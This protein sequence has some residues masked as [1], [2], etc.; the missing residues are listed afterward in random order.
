MFVI[1]HSYVALLDDNALENKIYNV[2]PKEKVLQNLDR[3]NNYKIYNTRLMVKMN[4]FYR[5]WHR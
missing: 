1:N 3:V 2:F 5:H 4:R